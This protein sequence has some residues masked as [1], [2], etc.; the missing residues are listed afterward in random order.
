MVD[1]HDENASESESTK[2]TQMEDDEAADHLLDNKTNKTRNH[3]IILDSIRTICPN[4]RMYEVVRSVKYNTYKHGASRH[5]AKTK[6]QH[7]LGTNKH[8]TRPRRLQMTTKL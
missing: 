2:D 3:P 4:V 5:T 7:V 8:G 6:V 1:S